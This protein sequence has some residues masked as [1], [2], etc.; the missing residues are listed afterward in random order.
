[1][2]G[3]V[4]VGC[5]GTATFLQVLYWRPM[6]DSFNKG[7]PRMSGIAHLEVADG[8]VF[9]LLLPSSFP[10]HLSLCIA[11]AGPSAPEQRLGPVLVCLER[12]LMVLR[13]YKGTN[14]SN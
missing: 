11:A 14:Q 2:Q 4:P 6:N 12:P 9:L 13:I 1:M 7:A 3:D 8:V 5:K 10:I